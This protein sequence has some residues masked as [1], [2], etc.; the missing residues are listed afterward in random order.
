MA[1]RSLSLPRIWTYD[2]D[3]QRLN[4]LLGLDEEKE[5]CLAMAL[6]PGK[7]PKEQGAYAL[8][9]NLH[10]KDRQA[11]RVAHNI[12]EYPR[13]LEIHKAGFERVSSP[14]E[15]SQMWASL[16]VTPPEWLQLSLP[17]SW[18]ETYNYPQALQQR[19]SRRNFM[20][21]PLPFSGLRAFIAGLTSEDQPMDALAMGMLVGR[22]EG[23]EP[24]FYG[25]DIA[26]RSLGLVSRGFMMDEM[27]SVCLDQKWL[28]MASIHFLFLANLSVLDRDWG[29]RGYRYAMM[30]AGRLGERI[31]L[32]A[33]AMGLGCCGIGALYDEEAAALLGLNEDSRL[34]YVV[35]VGPV[36]GTVNPSCSTP[37]CLNVK[38]EIPICV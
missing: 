20:R 2:F 10:E 5:V 19:R 6:V 30:A 21:S 36:M 31:Y 8:P 14:K 1:L 22:T 13:I 37:P 16:G 18:H 32:M 27:A 3:D 24:G 11:S 4:H 28:S 35:A 25:V 23:L 33:T 12:K 26:T 7:D 17:S 9:P 38:R 34:L 15:R 29:S